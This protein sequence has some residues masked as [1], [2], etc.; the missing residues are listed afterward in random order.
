MV[1]EWKKDN[2]SLLTKYMSWTWKC[3]PLTL[4]I[5][6]Y[7][8]SGFL[9]YPIQNFNFSAFPAPWGRPPW[10][11]QRRCRPRQWGS[12]MG[13]PRKGSSLRMSRLETHSLLS[14]ASMNRSA[15]ENIGLQLI[16]WNRETNQVVSWTIGL[17]SDHVPPSNTLKVFL[18]LGY[19]W[20]EVCCLCNWNGC[21]DKCLSKSKACKPRRYAS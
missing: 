3:L 11:Q 20:Q 18:F 9:L 17:I 7:I 8:F 2:L 6:L 12:S 4:Y 19:K 21:P 14:S 15:Y 10:R 1:V 5:F 13:K 16:G